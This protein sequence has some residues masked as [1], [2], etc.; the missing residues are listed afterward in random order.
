MSLSKSF[1]NKM[2][3]SLPE[4]HIT[5]VCHTRKETPQCIC[6]E[7]SV[8]LEAAF[9]IPCLVCFFVTILFFFRVIQVQLAI[10]EAADHTAGKLAVYMAAGYEKERWEKKSA[11]RLLLTKE[12]EKSGVSDTYLKGGESGIKIGESD[13]SKEDIS[14]KLKY[15]FR[16]PIRFFG[17]LELSSS[18]VAVT[19]KWT[20]WIDT[21]D[22]RDT[23]DLWVYIARTGS[24]YHKSDDCTHLTLSIQ[25]VE[26]SSVKNLRNENGGKYK[27]C[28]FCAKVNNK[29]NHVYITNQGDRFHYDLNCGGIKR[30]VSKIRLTEAGGRKPCSRCYRVSK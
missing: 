9:V 18:S 8:S 1:Q 2:K 7:G 30:T 22:N 14:L 13:W 19:R 21:E 6:R 17:L 20:G 3:D 24:T 16:C 27:K 15:R 29:W 5:D 11:V 4:N 25:S 26:E 28:K 12:L 23:S 10:Q